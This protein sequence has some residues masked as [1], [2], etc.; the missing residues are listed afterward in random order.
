MT[1]MQPD[2]FSKDVRRALLRPSPMPEDRGLLAVDMALRRL[3]GTDTPCDLRGAL[4]RDLAEIL[5]W[6][7]YGNYGD[8][9]YHAFSSS[10][11][12]SE[13]SDGSPDP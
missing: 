2:S 6:T 8:G 1:S 10:T 3:D 11:E 5:D 12:G 9:E 4:R 7:M 13:G